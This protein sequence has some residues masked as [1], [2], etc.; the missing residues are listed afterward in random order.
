MGDSIDYNDGLSISNSS[1]K[2]R[3][4]GESPIA[5]I[6]QYDGY[7]YQLDKYIN[8][9][10]AD[11]IEKVRSDIVRIGRKL[12]QIM[13]KDHER[14]EKIKKDT[15]LLIDSL[16]GTLEKYERDLEDA[17]ETEQKA[18]LEK[19]KAIKIIQKNPEM[20]KDKNL[21]DSVRSGINSAINN[22]EDQA[23][24]LSISGLIGHFA[25]AFQDTKFE[26]RP[27]EEIP[28]RLYPPKNEFD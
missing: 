4:L 5:L 28:W 26:Y 15:N 18:I 19:I 14:Y 11:D 1:H 21:V 9:L 6:K 25:R 20:K 8:S 10:T 22:I 23:Q 12:M 3:I 7:Y 13:G 24:K 17:P 2:Q 16:K 27:I